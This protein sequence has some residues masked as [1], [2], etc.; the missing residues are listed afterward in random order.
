MIILNHPLFVLFVTAAV[1]FFLL[2]LPAYWIWK[3]TMRGRQMVLS[4][5]VLALIW[6]ARFLVCIFGKFSMD[7]GM[8]SLNGLEAVFNSLVHALQTFSMDEEYTMFISAGKDAL[9]EMGLPNMAVGYGFLTSLLNVLAPILGGTLLLTVLTKLFPEILILCYPRRHKYVFSCLN[10]QAVCLAEDICRNRNYEILDAFSDKNKRPLIVFTDAY[11]DDESEQ[12]SELLERAMNLRALCIKKDLR[13]LSLRRSRSVTYLLI[14]EVTERNLQAFSELTNPNTERQLWPLPSDAESPATRIVVFVQKDHE[15]DLVKNIM[16]ERDLPPL[17]TVRIIRD[18]MNAAVNLMFDVPLY[19]PL[20]DQ[21][22]QEESQLHIVIFGSGSIAE[23][24]LRTVFWCGQMLNTKVFVDVIARDAGTLEKKLRT[25]CPELLESC[26]QFSDILTVY[27]ESPHKRRNPPYLAHIGFTD[28][29]DVQNLES[30]DP[31]LLQA[32][33]YCIIALGSDQANLAMTN[34]IKLALAKRNLTEQTGSL[35]IVPAIFDT[36]I[37]EAMMMQTQDTDKI[38]LIPFATNRSRFSV[39]NVFMQNFM[40]SAVATA[41]LYGP[42]EQ[43]KMLT[44]EYTYWAN[45]ARS[46]HASYKLFSIGVLKSVN[47][48]EKTPERRYQLRS[49][50]VLRSLQQTVSGEK[51]PQES[52]ESRQLAW[53]EHRRWNA[54]LRSQ[55]FVCA[56]GNMHEAIY[57]KTQQHKSIPLRLHPCLVECSDVLRDL[58]YLDSFD[59]SELDG[60][61]LVSVKRCELDCPNERTADFMQA[62]NYKI[63]DYPSHDDTLNQLIR[64]CAPG[65]KEAGA[66]KDAQQASA[67]EKK[68][69]PFCRQPMQIGYL[70]ATGRMF[71][72]GEKKNRFVRPDSKD[73]PITNA[74]KFPNRSAQSAYY[75]R[76]CHTILVMKQSQNGHRRKAAS[77]GSGNAP[78]RRRPADPRRQRPR[79]KDPS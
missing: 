60:L 6:F 41:N 3:K 16:R 50:R 54:F 32:M 55:G 49:G 69:C 17:M 30:L 15:A 46:V 35:V 71:W 8:N 27:P 29:E 67:A 47:L 58:P 9:T 33:N 70:Q 24:T 25:A 61:D 66:Q 10:E 20:L 26:D 13:N 79:R 19:L 76:N 53:L 22:Q 68:N 18:Y 40:E 31:K 45:L 48:A 78:K 57:R 23:E 75:C 36:Q 14:D 21:K 73:Y 72:S 7:S 63:W 74:G 59:R 5:H 37:A 34:S 28:H 42:K 39:K 52:T 64:L 11:G 56:D 44:D 51:E 65:K 38:R 12:H 43:Q 2:I 1:V 4:L 62:K 77:Q